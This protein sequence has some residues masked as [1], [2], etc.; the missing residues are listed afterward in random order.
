MPARLRLAI[1]TR[2][3]AAKGRIIRQVDP[4]VA[5]VVGVC[6]GLPVSAFLVPRDAVADLWLFSLAMLRAVRRTSPGDLARIRAS[7]AAIAALVKTDKAVEAARFIDVI[8]AVLFADQKTVDFNRALLLAAQ[9]HSVFPREVVA[10]I[11][12]PSWRIGVMRALSPH[13]RSV[14]DLIAEAKTNRSIARETGLSETTIKSI[15]RSI[16]N[17]LQFHN[18]TEVAMFMLREGTDP[19]MRAH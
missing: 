9:R 11:T 14:L 16:M 4:A 1:A 17:K 15:V 5:E 18:R 19:G 2:S 3:V 12:R 13:E 8:D 6:D 10:A 7:G